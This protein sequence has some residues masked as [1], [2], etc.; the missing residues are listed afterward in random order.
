VFCRLDHNS[1]SVLARQP[2]LVS[3]DTVPCWTLVTGASCEQGCMTAPTTEAAQVF[4]LFRHE[5]VVSIGTLAARRTRERGARSPTVF[6]NVTVHWPQH[7]MHRPARLGHRVRTC[8]VRPGL[9]P[10]LFASA[11]PLTQTVQGATGSRVKRLSFSAHGTLTFT[12]PCSGQPCSGHLTR[13]TSNTTKVLYW[14]LS[15]CR[16]R[17][18]SQA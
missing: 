16:H 13:G 14:Q 5:L 3:Q 9:P 6:A 17:R 7:R 10:S 1:A 18:R 4:R 12:V 11:M 2:E 8:V 15:R